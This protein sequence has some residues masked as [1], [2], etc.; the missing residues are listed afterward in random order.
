[1]S[2]DAGAGF[3]ELR[4]GNLGVRIATDAGEV[5]AAQALRYRIFYEELGAHPDEETALLR[6]DCDDFDAVA[7][8]LLV[9]DHDLG[10]GSAGVVGTYRLIRRGA[11]ARV[12]GFYSAS[13]YDLGP[14]LSQPGE[15]L[16]LGRSCVDERYRNRQAMQLLWSGIAAYVSRH[17][18]GLMFGCAS[19]PGTDLDQ[20]ASPLSYLHSSHLAPPELR[21]RALTERFVAMDR[22]DPASIDPRQALAELPPLVKGY[23]RLGGFVGDG[24]VVDQQFNTTDVCVVVKTELVTE[25]YSRHYERKMGGGD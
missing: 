11:A 20:L 9:L 18:I 15:I 7:D 4:T 2:L 25:K 1:M 3:G 14:L 16:E 17:Q 10:E 23:L 6:R 13:E 24:A 22:L 21:P 5:E 8:H 19:L 12:G